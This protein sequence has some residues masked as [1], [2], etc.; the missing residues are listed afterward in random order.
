LEDRVIIVTGASRGIGYAIA[1]RLAWEGARVV[2]AAKSVTENPQLPGTI[3]QTVSDIESAGGQALGVACNVRHE[4]ELQ[5]LVDATLAK[6]GRIDGLI[7]NAGAIW[8][9]PIERTPAKRLDLVHEVNYRAPYLLSRLVL[10]HMLAG[11]WGHILNMSPPLDPAVIGG[12]I[13]YIVSKFNMTML[14]FG[15][16]QE[17]R[18]QGANIAVNSL[19]PKTLIESLAT[20]NWQ[21]GEP[22][23]WRKA[24]IMADATATIFAQEPRDYSGGALIDEDVLRERA[25]MTDF[26]HY[27]VVPGGQP[28]DLEWETFAAVIEK[29]KQS[30]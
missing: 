7:N 28:V 22:K 18:Q 24:D 8:I 25:G 10:P 21:M 23:D 12:K 16:A 30:S 20:I 26:S 3:Q 5:A 15:L 6:W 2:V 1:R 13:A 14:T 29:M 27:N 11:G 19:W 4:S 17:L 9:E